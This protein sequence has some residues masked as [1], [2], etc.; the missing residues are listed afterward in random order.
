AH[1]LRG[2]S[3]AIRRH[4]QVVVQKHSHR[5]KRRDRSKRTNRRAIRGGEESLLHHDMRAHLID[6]SV[7][8]HFAPPGT[9]APSSVRSKFSASAPRPA[10]PGMYVATGAFAI[11]P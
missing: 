10:P 8:A 11:L 2:R 3:H 5:A 6:L 1:R 9:T 4:R 7:D